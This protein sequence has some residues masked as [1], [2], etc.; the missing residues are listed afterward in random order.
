MDSLNKNIM[1][2]LR[3]SILKF[4]F[5]AII[6]LLWFDVK[7]QNLL[8]ADSTQI[9][10]IMLEQG[11]SQNKS[12]LE[13]NLGFKGTFRILFFT[14]HDGKANNGIIFKKFYLTLNNMCVKYDVFYNGEKWA[15]KLKDS[16]NMPSMGLKQMKDSLEWIS[17]DKSYYVNIFKSITIRGENYPSCRLVVRNSNLIPATN[18]FDT[19]N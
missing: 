6:N 16:L 1:K 9:K 12:H 4:I 19:K 15:N 14:F 3:S 10:K 17:S 5:L 8:G 18:P 13:E 7:G 11:A 2:N